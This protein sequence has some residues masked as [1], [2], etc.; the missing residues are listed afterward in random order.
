[1]LWVVVVIV[2]LESNMKGKWEKLVASFFAFKKV[3]IFFYY[4][5]YIFSLYVSQCILISK[6][7]GLPGLFIGPHLLIFSSILIFSFF[8]IF[9][10]LHL[11]I[12]L[13]FCILI[14]LSSNSFIERLKLLLFISVSISL[15]A[16][17]F[18]P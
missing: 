7:L 18:N 5:D 17:R 10:L 1:V 9:N 14:S 13:S 11:S 16:H 12:L 6:S 8:F 15:P 4:Y 2:S 3:R